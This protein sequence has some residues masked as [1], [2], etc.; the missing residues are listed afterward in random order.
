LNI[1]RVPWLVIIELF[2]GDH[3]FKPFASAPNG[4]RYW[5][6]GGTLILSTG[7]KT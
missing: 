5:R 2:F 4:L 1:G 6:V 7:K 3:I